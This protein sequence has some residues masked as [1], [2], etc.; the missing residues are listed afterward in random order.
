MK[1][2]VLLQLSLTVLAFTLLDMQ[3][4]PAAQTLQATSNPMQFSGFKTEMSLSATSAEMQFTGS[5]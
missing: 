3:S 1:I 5:H 4:A 2:R